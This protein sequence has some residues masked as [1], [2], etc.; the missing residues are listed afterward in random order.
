MLHVYCYC[1]V[2]VS[3][4]MMKFLIFDYF[5]EAVYRALPVLTASPTAQVIIIIV[6]NHI[7]LYVVFSKRSNGC[8]SV[9]L[10]LIYGIAVTIAYSTLAERN[11]YNCC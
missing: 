7:L 11:L 1:V 8:S 3:F 5:S 9:I 10:P 4:G 2:Q 6:I